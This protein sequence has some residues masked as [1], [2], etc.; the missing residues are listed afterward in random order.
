M[1]AQ[2]QT[3]ATLLASPVYQFARELMD[4]RGSFTVEL[5]RWDPLL[6]ASVHKP[7]G[8]HVIALAQS[9]VSQVEQ[10]CQAQPKK[11]RARKARR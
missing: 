5:I 4:L 6:N 10:A 9:Y 8:G 2:A 7:V 11:R 1:K 3:L